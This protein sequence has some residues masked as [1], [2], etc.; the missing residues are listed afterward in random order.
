[1]NRRSLLK[2]IG[3]APCVPAAALVP[4]APPAP[5]RGSHTVSTVSMPGNEVAGRYIYYIGADGKP[6]RLGKFTS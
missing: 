2:L 6:V 5:K 1:M 3:L 4:T